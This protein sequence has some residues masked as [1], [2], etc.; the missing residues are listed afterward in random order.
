MQQQIFEVRA[1][2]GNLINHHLAK[3]ITLGVGPAPLRL[4]RAVLHEHGH[5][6]FARRRHGGVILGGYE[7]V[8]VGIGRPAVLLPVIIGALKPLQRVSEMHMAQR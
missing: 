6:M 7:R 5:H 4:H 2:L 8:A 1:V 3:G